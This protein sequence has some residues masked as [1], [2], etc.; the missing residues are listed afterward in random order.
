MSQSSSVHTPVNAIGTKRRRMLDWPI[1][2]VRVT[3]SGPSAVLVTR[4]KLGAWSPILSDMVIGWLWLSAR[5]SER[6]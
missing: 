5:I 6:C 3:V 1:W 4:V 2:S